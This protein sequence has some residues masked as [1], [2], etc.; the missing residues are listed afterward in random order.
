M[1]LLLFKPAVYGSFFETD[2][3]LTLLGGL[4]M[5]GGILA[6]VVLWAYN[7]SFQTFLR[8]DRRFDRFTTSRRFMH[9]AQLLAAAHLLM[10]GYEEWLAPDGWQGGLPPLSLVAFL[11][12]ILGSAFNLFGRG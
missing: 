1:S 7:L 11:I 4:S 3:T 5:L 12:F 10:L 6:F 2:G 9:Y 8:E